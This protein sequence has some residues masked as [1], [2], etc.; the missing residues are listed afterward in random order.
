MYRPLRY[1]KQTLYRI[2]EIAYAKPVSTY[3]IGIVLAGGR[4]GCRLR[5]AKLCHH[6]TPAGNPRLLASLD[7]FKNATKWMSKPFGHFQDGSV[8]LKF[9][10]PDQTSARCSPERP[11]PELVSER[12]LSASNARALE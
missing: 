3:D 12:I 6:L 4:R 9:F 11:N 5:R 7:C 8:V 1:S 10:A 2:L